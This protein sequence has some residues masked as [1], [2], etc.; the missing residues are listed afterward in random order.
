MITKRTLSKIQKI[1]QRGDVKI[2]SN[3]SGFTERKISYVIKT[4]RGEA[5]DSVIAFYTAR[6]EKMERTNKRFNKSPIK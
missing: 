4:G 5:E 3:A 6:L 2:I 1:K